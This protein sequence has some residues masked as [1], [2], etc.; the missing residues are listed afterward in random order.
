MICLITVDQLWRSYIKKP[1]VL[2]GPSLG[3]AVAIDF[4]AN[5]PE[6][7]LIVHL[8]FSYSVHRVEN[9]CIEHMIFFI[10]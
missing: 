10:L 2:V 9:F 5:H 6:A 1:M 8:S 3:A 7:V 4:V